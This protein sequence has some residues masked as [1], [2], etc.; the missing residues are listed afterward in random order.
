MVKC[1]TRRDENRGAENKGTESRGAGDREGD[2][3]DREA[4]VVDRSFKV[5]RTSQDAKYMV[6]HWVN[7]ALDMGV[8]RLMEEFKYSLSK[9]QPEGMTVTAFLANRDKNRY[10]DVPCQD[11]RRV[12]VRWPGLPNDYIHANYVAN[13]TVDNRFICAQVEKALSVES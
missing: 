1:E 12:V 4:Q 2:G 10:L 13:P 7:R 5:A 3:A 9:W 6:Q 11:Y 8:P